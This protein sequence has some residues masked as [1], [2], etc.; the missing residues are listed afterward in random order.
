MSTRAGKSLIEPC[1]RICVAADSPSP[2]ENA[3]YSNKQYYDYN[4]S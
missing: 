4:Y 1:Q 3:H 2:S